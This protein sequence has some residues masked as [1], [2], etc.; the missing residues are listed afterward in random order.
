MYVKMLYFSFATL[1][2]S[3][4]LAKKSSIASL[5]Q[6]AT[7]GSCQVLRIKL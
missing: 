6:G 7:L 5:H 2:I 4:N 1:P 3:E